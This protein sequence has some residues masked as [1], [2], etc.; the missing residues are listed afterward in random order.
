MGFGARKLCQA[1]VLQ[2]SNVRVFFDWMKGSYCHCFVGA[3][4]DYYSV[5]LVC[6][7]V[8]LYVT[9]VIAIPHMA[10]E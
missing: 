4:A 9:L 10:I 6:G 3:M 2:V 8:S 7:F 1:R 5:F